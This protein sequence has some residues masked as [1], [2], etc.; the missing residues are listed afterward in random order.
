MSRRL[1]F[2]VGVLLGWEE[3]MDGGGF[4]KGKNWND[5]STLKCPTN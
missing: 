2:V 5:K 4:K 1:L 3:E